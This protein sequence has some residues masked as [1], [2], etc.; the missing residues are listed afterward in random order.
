MGDP[1]FPVVESEFVGMI[2]LKNMFCETNTRVEPKA[3]TRPK[4]LDIVMSKEQASMTPRVSGKSER[5]VAGEYETPNKKAYASTV[6]S[7]DRA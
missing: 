2:F 4:K 7:G 1:W 6:T 3:Q 5:Y